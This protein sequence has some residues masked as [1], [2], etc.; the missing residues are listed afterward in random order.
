MDHQEAAED[1][2]TELTRRS[3][4]DWYPSKSFNGLEPLAT[5]RTPF[6]QF[7]QPPGIHNELPAVDAPAGRVFLAGE[8]TELSSIQGALEIG[9]RTARVAIRVLVAP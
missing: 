7:A 4:S 6:A 1:K 3:L 5:Y 8:Y 2:M 9:R